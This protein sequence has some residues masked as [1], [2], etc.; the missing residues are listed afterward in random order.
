MGIKT[1]DTR[2]FPE[3][4]RFWHYSFV[5]FRVD[6]KMMSEKHIDKL[7]AMTDS[8]YQLS[9]AVAK[10]A[11]QLKAG[12]VPVIPPEQ[13][14]TR[15]LVTV[16]MRELASGHLEMGNNLVDDHKL[17]HFLVR[18][19]QQQHELAQQ[20]AAQSYTMPDFDGD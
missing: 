17:E 3:Q 10:R 4:F 20:Q 12:V 15:N 18:S 16:A 2:D 7:L 8:K 19:K 11:I 5:F 14:A 9:V 13:R 1:C 6:C